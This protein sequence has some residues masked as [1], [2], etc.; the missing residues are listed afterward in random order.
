MEHAEEMNAILE[1]IP[2]PAFI[3]RDGLIV[4]ANSPALQR[5]LAPGCPIHDLLLT[6]GEEYADFAGGCLYLTLNCCGVPSSVSVT[7]MGEGLH[8]FI[9]EQEE[10]L[11]ELQSM[12]LAAQALRGPLSNVMTVADQLFP[13]VNEDDSPRAQEQIARINRGLF[14]MLRIISN[15]SDAYRYSSEHMPRMDLMNITAVIRE[16]LDQAA[17]LLAHTGI[18]LQYEGQQEPVYCLIDQEKLERA[19]NN[20][21]SNAIKFSPKGSTIRA[22]LR[23]RGKMLYF[24]IQ[25]NG[26]GIPQHLRSSLYNRYHRQPGIEDSR[27]GIGLG[28]VLVRRAAMAHGGTVL[29]EEGTDFGLRVTMTILI[30]Q[31]TDTQVRCPMFRVDYAGE[32]S[33]AL[34]ELSDCLPPELY[35]A[36][37]VN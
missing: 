26:S 8:L 15:M 6:G 11:A 14:Q 3:V 29:I 2:L 28:M 35:E 1:Q 30:R 4:H 24:S 34:I 22:A 32:R 13:L 23:R 31:T 18:Q 36:D 19:V 12:A 17:P 5:Q 25:D 33:H 9:F 27:F 21:I 20:L 7:R 10:D 37:N 16:V